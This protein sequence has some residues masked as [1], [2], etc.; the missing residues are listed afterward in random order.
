MKAITL[1]VMILTCSQIHSQVIWKENIKDNSGGKILVKKHFTNEDNLETINWLHESTS[2][3]LNDLKAGYYS[4]VYSN[5]LCSR[6]IDETVHRCDELLSKDKI[7]QLIIEKKVNSK[8]DVYRINHSIDQKLYYRWSFEDKVFYGNK[9][10]L[11]NR[12]SPLK[13]NI[14]DGC[15]EIEYEIPYLQDENYVVKK[16]TLH[17]NE[18][19][20]KDFISISPNPTKNN[21]TLKSTEANMYNLIRV[22]S[23]EGV[24]VQSINTSDNELVRELD[25]QHLSSGFYNLVF[26][27]NEVVVDHS[28]FIKL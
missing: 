3:E 1:I 6:R 2:F 25:V 13:L 17:G 27:L 15:S 28:E 11:Y 5:H 16:L 14:T 26:L 9:L 21:L 7:I 8:R 18:N 19:S 24:L 23:S 4:A 12:K 22:Y 10:E 20:N